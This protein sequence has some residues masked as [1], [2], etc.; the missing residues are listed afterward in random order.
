[1][2]TYEIYV[3]TMNSCGG[4]EHR[5]RR[6]I[7]MDAQNPVDYVMAYSRWPV[8]ESYRNEKGDLMIVTGDQYGSIIRYTIL[9]ADHL[10]VCIG[11]VIA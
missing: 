8:R 3:E 4:E 9:E 11:H 10:N 5:K 6:L 7:E 1:M 2:R